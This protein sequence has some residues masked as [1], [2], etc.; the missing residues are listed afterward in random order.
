MQEEFMN[1]YQ[2]T[3]ESLFH[4]EN[5]SEIESEMFLSSPTYHSAAVYLMQYSEFKYENYNELLFGKSEAAPLF[6][7]GT[8]LPFSKKVFVTVNG[9]ILPCERIGHQFALGEIKNGS[10]NLD[11]EE[12]AKKYNQY[13]AKIDKQCS[14]CHNSKSCIQCI[15]NLDDIEKDKCSCFGFMNKEKFENFKN[16]QLSFLARHPDA[17]ARIMNDVLYR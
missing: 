15:F 16:T 1:M 12:I 4:S 17:Y 13:F 14:N 11:F 2:N 9:K 8:C 7:S 6:P 3:F 5:Y 10:V